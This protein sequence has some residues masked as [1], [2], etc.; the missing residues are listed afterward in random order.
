MSRRSSGQT[1]RESL[2]PGADGAGNSLLFGSPSGQMVKKSCFPAPK[3]PGK[4]RGLWNLL[5]FFLSFF[6]F[7][8]SPTTLLNSLDG[9]SNSH[10]LG[11]GR[12][13][14]LG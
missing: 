7:T 1:H 3:A 13:T 12:L 6:L 5:S 11:M 14:G 9:A 8:L 10:L 4:F 2:H